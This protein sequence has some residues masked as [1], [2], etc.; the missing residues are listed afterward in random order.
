ME[1]ATVTARHSV[2]PIILFVG[3]SDSL[4]AYTSRFDAA[5]LW[6]ATARTPDAMDAVAELAPNLVVTEI[7]VE[8]PYGRGDLVSALRR[9]L[10]TREVPIIVLTEQRRAEL[11]SHIVRQAD[12]VLVKPVLPNTLLTRVTDLLSWSKVLQARSTKALAQ[13]AKVRARASDAL[14]RSARVKADLKSTFR[15]CPSCGCGLEWLERSKIRGLEYDYYRWC[16]NGCGLFCYELRT[17]SQDP[18]WI[19]LA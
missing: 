10:S 12:L 8:A 19:R 1:S 7:D 17:P 16:R 3:N 6:M 15:A 18:R 5:G 11:P 2:P 9:D 13:A 14:D 4:D